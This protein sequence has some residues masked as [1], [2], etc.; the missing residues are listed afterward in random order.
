M[1]EIFGWGAA[2]T[3]GLARLPQ[4]YKLYKTKKGDDI[5]LKTYLVWTLHTILFVIYAILQKDI[6][7][8]IMGCNG[9]I[10]NCTILGLKWYYK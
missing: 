2:I 4:I 9:F 6:I 7:L 5:S 8:T 1:Q 10:Q 3:A